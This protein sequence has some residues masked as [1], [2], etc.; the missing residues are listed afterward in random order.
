MSIASH[1]IYPKGDQI[2]A[3]KTKACIFVAF[4]YK[5]NNKEKVFLEYF[6]AVAFLSTIHAFFECCTAPFIK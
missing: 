1:D 4:I 3:Y 5:V 6:L 2:N